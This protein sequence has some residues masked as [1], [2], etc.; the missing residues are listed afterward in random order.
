MFAI[1]LPGGVFYISSL[2][3]TLFSE[4]R[5]RAA[6]GL[7][8]L[9]GRPTHPRNDIYLGSNISAW[10]LSGVHFVVIVGN[11]LPRRGL[12]SRIWP[13]GWALLRHKSAAY[14]RSASSFAT[15]AQTARALTWAKLG[16]WVQPCDKS[17]YEFRPIFAR[18]AG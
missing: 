3:M 18:S 12:L 15:P 16:N 5:G 17:L 7:R 13:T 2:F 10:R 8:R 14:K 9:S 1:S 11:D 4:L 6:I